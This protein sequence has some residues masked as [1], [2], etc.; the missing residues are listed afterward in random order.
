MFFCYSVQKGSQFFCYSVEV[1]LKSFC[2]FT[3]YVYLC[4]RISCR[5]DNNV[6]YNIFSNSLKPAN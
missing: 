2:A 6:I 1:F 5:D 4:R 3:N